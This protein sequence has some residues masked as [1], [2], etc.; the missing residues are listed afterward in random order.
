VKPR[1][2][3]REEECP[4]SCP[5]SDMSQRLG[6]SRTVRLREPSIRSGPARKFPFS[7]A[8]VFFSKEVGTLTPGRPRST[9]TGEPPVKR[10]GDCASAGAPSMVSEPPENQDVK[11]GIWYKIGFVH[12]KLSRADLFHTFSTKANEVG[13]IAFIDDEKEISDRSRPIGSC[14]QKIGNALFRK[15]CTAHH[16]SHPLR[17]LNRCNQIPIKTVLAPV[18]GEPVSL[19]GL[20]IAERSLTR[21]T[22]DVEQ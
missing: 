13:P 14:G 1:D 21:P 10:D 7:E 9:T 8:P 16:L 20:G 6:I 19:D 2:E 12:L 11:I 3:A 18:F 5:K 17:P 15:R 4:G 22:G